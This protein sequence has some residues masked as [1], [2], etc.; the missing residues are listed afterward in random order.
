MDTDTISSP[1]AE[2]HE[3]RRRTAVV[4]AAGLIG[5]ALVAAL[6]ARTSM[7]AFT[8]TT[9]S[10]GNSFDI[11]SVALTDD[12]SDGALFSLTGLAPG[13]SNQACIAVTY[14]GSLTSTG[15]VKLYA[16]SGRTDVA[17]TGGD[18][19]ADYL[20]VTVEQGTGGGYGSCAGFAPTSTLVTGTA[21]SALPT[22]YASGVTAWTPTAT[23]QTR[24]YR[25][26]VQLD[27]TTP[28]GAQ[29]ASTSNVRFTWEIQS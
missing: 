14:A 4:L 22:D 11:G 18:D 6:V 3:T 5:L 28:N 8:A 20:L 26:T 16:P 24:T 15:P 2:S 13:Q 23:P 9:Q 1:Q 21:L 25:F 19:A 27:P 17:G 12:D 29:D 10:P 7:A